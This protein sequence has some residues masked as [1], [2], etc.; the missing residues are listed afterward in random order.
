MHLLLY[1]AF[2]EHV[3][4]HSLLLLLLLCAAGMQ[5]WGHQLLDANTD[6]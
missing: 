5:W 3:C 2:T 4:H 6:C 1:L